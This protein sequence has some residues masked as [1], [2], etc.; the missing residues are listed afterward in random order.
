MAEA[1]SLKLKQWRFE[2]SREYQAR[3]SQLVEDA[4][5]KAVMSEFES[6]GGHQGP[7]SPTGRRRLP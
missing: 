5:S 6:Q 7:G 3:L 2:S 1:F 4:V